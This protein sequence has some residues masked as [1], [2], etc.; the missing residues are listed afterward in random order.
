MAKNS[1]TNFVVSQN[2]QFSYRI[3]DSVRRSQFPFDKSIKLRFHNAAE[4]CLSYFKT[5][6]KLKGNSSRISGSWRDDMWAILVHEPVGMSLGSAHALW[7]VAICLQSQ[8]KEGHR[9]IRDIKT[10][11]K[12][13]SPG[14]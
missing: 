13:G 9:A 3:R 2:R 10:N 6:L 12:T 11:E 5:A 4:C 14:I 8:G 1:L 7:W